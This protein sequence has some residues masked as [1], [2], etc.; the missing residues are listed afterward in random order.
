MAPR[1]QILKSENIR[2][3]RDQIMRDSVLPPD[4]VPVHRPLPN[5]R[6][7]L[8]TGTTGFLGRYL[9]ATL[10]QETDWEVVCLVRAADE[11]S[12][13]QRL[14]EALA[15]TG[16][17]VSDSATR[18]SV[19]CGDV[20]R[21]HFGLSS[22]QFERLAADVHMVFHAAAEVNWIKSYAALRQSN[23]LGTLHAIQLAC[24]GYAKPFYFVSTLAV[25]YAQDGPEQVTETTDMSDHIERMP[26]GYAQSKYVSEML[27][28][29]ATERGLPVTVIRPSLISGDSE[30]G[31][32]NEE[33]LISRL[34]KGCI[35]MG[36]AAD[37]DWQLDCCPV[38]RVAAVIVS[39]ARNHADGFHVLHLHHPNPRH[40][41]ELVLWLNL[42]GYRLPLLDLDDWLERLAMTTRH[43]CR[44]LFALRPFFL[45]RPTSLKGRRLPELYLEPTRQRIRS[46]HSHRV[47]ASH[48]LQ[49]PAI[50]APLLGKYFSRFLDS[51]FIPVVPEPMLRVQPAFE[52][53]CDY[54]EE[55]LRQEFSDIGLC[56]LSRSSTRIGTNSIINE[57]CSARG[58]REVGIWRHSV[59]YRR[60]DQSVDDHVELLVK[61][62][63]DDKITERIA[64]TIGALNG[65]KLA[66]VA[67][68]LP[69]ALGITG[70]HERE[71][72]LCTSSDDR[73]RHHM[74]KIYGTYA[75]PASGVWLLVMEYLTQT[76]M[77]DSIDAG[78]PWTDDH[79]RCAITGLADIHSV[80]YRKENEL[81][82]QNWLAPKLSTDDVHLMQPLWHAL[83]DAAAN[84]FSTAWNIPSRPLQQRIVEKLPIWWEELSNL[85]QTLIHNDFNP[86]NVAF[87][88]EED[89][90]RLC[91][92][93]WELATIGVPQHDLAELLCFVLPETANEIM[94]RQFLELHRQKLEQAYGASIPVSDWETG[95]RLSLCSL[96]VN[97]L[98]LYIL[99]SKFKPQVF[100]PKVLQNWYRLYQWFDDM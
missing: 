97:R 5:Q 95:F 38:D 48:G 21:P 37:V 42:F 30:T 67:H 91:A 62:K 39:L 22:T 88:R 58:G 74:P 3:F 92:Y 14:N 46:N 53:A 9:V 16:R 68:L 1:T 10:L 47:I 20:A 100:L 94:A 54:L 98:P 26:L 18:V 12:G 35:S 15:Q 43:S 78:I 82:Q 66:A 19:V 24:H 28:R 40:W 73:L 71:L 64:K 63:T 11:S 41:R 51:G 29:H 65:R 36:Y 76:E 59:R 55:L 32:S 44:E 52:V 85:P 75:D 25:C 93:D 70:A 31:I 69:H 56:V 34:I 90:L 6:R 87:R 80:W 27:L 89:G 77:L 72:L 50:D 99:I 4:I 60:T 49:L 2:A 17:D 45:S 86:R 13:R 8:V 33:D 7:V 83:S 61:I 81:R 57:L 96:A 84:H 23:V 79:I